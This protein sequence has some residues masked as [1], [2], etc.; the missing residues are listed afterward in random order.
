MDFDDARGGPEWE[1][2]E[3]ETKRK[4]D[5]HPDSSLR[6]SLL[7]LTLYPSC[8]QTPSQILLRLFLIPKRSQFQCLYHL[9]EKEEKVRSKRTPRVRQECG[10]ALLLRRVSCV[11]WMTSESDVEA[12]SEVV[13][14]KVNLG[15][16]P[17]SQT[18]TPSLP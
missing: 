4:V 7:A 18:G 13:V 6:P 16:V 8:T 14:L 3:D 11:S 17:G 15:G 10:G 12:S 5:V 2:D 1:E 9:E